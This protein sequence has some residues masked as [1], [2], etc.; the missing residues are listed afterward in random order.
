MQKVFVICCNDALKTASLSIIE[1]RE[2]L[3]KLTKEETNEFCYW[4]IHEVKMIG[5][6]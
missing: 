2:E 1:A 3:A 5:G 6:D 4:H